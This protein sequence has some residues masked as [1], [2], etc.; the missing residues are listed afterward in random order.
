MMLY[1]YLVK[2]NIHGR[3]YYDCK[4]YLIFNIKI[5]TIYIFRKNIYIKEY[6]SYDA[7]YLVK[8][9][10]HGRIYYD[11][12]IYLIFNIK[13]KTYSYLRCEFG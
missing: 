2:L 3:I 6:I 11:S 10:I 13:I 4:I 1:I 9:N 7:I 5:K 12:K 8:L